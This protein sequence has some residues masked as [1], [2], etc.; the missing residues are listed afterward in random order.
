M[1]DEYASS[2]F[3]GSL[4][5]ECKSLTYKKIHSFTDIGV[6]ADSLGLAREA[7]DAA[8]GNYPPPDDC[9]FRPPT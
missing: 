5:N 7:G 2:G 4:V 9:L 8:T 3:E 1:S 6:A